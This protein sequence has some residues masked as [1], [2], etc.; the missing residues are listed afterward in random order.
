MAMRCDGQPSGSE[1][2]LSRRKCSRTPAARA[3]PIAACSDSAPVAGFHARRS[4]LRCPRGGRRE[5]RVR[6]VLTVSNLGS[7]ASG[8]IV[9]PRSRHLGCLTRSVGSRSVAEPV[10]EDVRPSNDRTRHAGLVCRAHDWRGRVENALIRSQ[11]PARFSQGS[12]FRPRRIQGS[13]TDTEGLESSASPANSSERRQ[14]GRLGLS[15]GR[16]SASGV[17]TRHA[18]HGPAGNQM[19]V[20]LNRV[21]GTPTIRRARLLGIGLLGIGPLVLAQAQASA[22]TAYVSNEK[23]NTISVVDIDKLTVVRTIKVG[24]RPRGIELTKDGKFILVAVGDDDT[25]QMI[26]TSTYEIAATL[27]SGPD[28]ELFTQDPTGKVLYVANENDN[29]VTII[30]MEKR[31]RIGE[32]QVGVEPEGMGI[33]PDGKML[34]NTSETTN[35]AHFIDTETRQIVAN[36]LVDARPRFA[37]VKRDGSELWVSSEIG[38]TVSVIDPVKHEVTAKITFEIPGLR[39]EAI[40]AV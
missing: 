32:V 1:H 40:Q 18:R 9:R 6:G 21:T 10:H 29:T 2:E 35:M 4:R 22:F 37:A 26:D 27:P 8:R 11:D 12:R 3:G 7:E 14:N 25:I 31:T 17:G 33:S 24:Q 36:V 5:R 23:S 34:V 38:G 19:Q 30:D 13:A 15:A 39:K 28:P 16:V 20:E